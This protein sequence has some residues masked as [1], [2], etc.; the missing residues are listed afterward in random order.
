M[1]ERSSYQ[2]YKEKWLQDLRPTGLG[3]P[4]QR[5]NGVVMVAVLWICALILWFALQISRETRLQ[6]DAEVHVLRRSQAIHLAMGGC[7]EAL[8]RMGQARPTGLERRADHTWQP[9]GSPRLV[10]YES[11]QAVVVVDAEARKVNVNKANHDQLKAVLI[12]GGLETHEA[13]RTA[14]VILDFVDEDDLVQLNGAEKEHY[15]SM[16]LPYGPLN[17]TLT[18]LDQLLLVPGI[19]PQIFYGYGLEQLSREDEDEFAE[20]R[21]PLMPRKHSLFQMFTVYGTNVSLS[22]DETGEDIQ[23]EQI[24]WESGATYRILSCGLPS[25]GAPAALVWLIVR[26]SPESEKGYEVLYRKIL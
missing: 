21:H 15:E 1:K 17:G 2:G 13:E 14:D 6:G 5:Q 23:S 9:D 4:L 8:G 24:T 3:S 20:L 11:G 16:G 25:G 26:Y 19:T 18:S 12:R 10:T 22:E 7:Y